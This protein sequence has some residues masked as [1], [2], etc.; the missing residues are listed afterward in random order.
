MLDE[1]LKN[2]DPKMVE[3]ILNEVIEVGASTSWDDIA[4]LH[5]VKEIIKVCPVGMLVR[6]VLNT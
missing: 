6:I 1:R 2:I 3:A 5:G 4:G